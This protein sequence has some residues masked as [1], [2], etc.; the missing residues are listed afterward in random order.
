MKKK[1]SIKNLAEYSGFHSA[2]EFEDCSV[3]EALVPSL[4][5]IRR[6]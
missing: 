4:C 3:A 2:E 1:Y 5:Y 6:V